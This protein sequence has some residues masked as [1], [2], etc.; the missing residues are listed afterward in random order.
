MEARN[1]CANKVMKALLKFKVS[2][3]DVDLR[4]WEPR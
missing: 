1:Y 2:D 4:K 3:L